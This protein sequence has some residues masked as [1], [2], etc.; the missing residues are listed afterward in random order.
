M[1]DIKKKFKIYPSSSGFLKENGELH[2]DYNSACIRYI[3]LSQGTDRI[4]IDPIYAILGAKH[5]DRYALLLGDKVEHR[6]FPIK[7][8]LSDLV[9]YSGRVDFITKDGL[10]HETKAS[11]SRS[12]LK[13][14]MDKGIAKNSHLAQ[15]VSYMTQL[16]R[17]EGKIVAGYYKSV[18]EMKD[19]K[20]FSVKIREDG[21]IVVDS[22]LTDFLIEDQLRHLYATTRSLEDGSIGPRPVSKGWNDPCRW[23]P[24]KAL[25]DSYDRSQLS[26]EELKEQAKVAINA[27]AAKKLTDK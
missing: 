15:I 18:N 12:F 1:T 26:E 3:V 22:K 5:E 20:V 6:E 4:E 10:I 27:K 11:M 19:F 9:E 13:D 7:R 17:T 14:H 21:R 25:C 24:V 2:V 8:D 16:E 23:C